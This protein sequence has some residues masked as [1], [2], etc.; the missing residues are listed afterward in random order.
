MCTVCDGVTFADPSPH[1][2]S[3]G[4]DDDTF[5]RFMLEMYEQ[6]TRQPELRQR[7]QV[8]P[9]ATVPDVCACT[10]YAVHVQ[11]LLTSRCHAVLCAAAGAGAATARGGAES[12]DPQGD[13]VVRAAAA[14]AAR[15]GQRRQAPAAAA[16]RA[17]RVH[18]HSHIWPLARVSFQSRFSWSCQVYYLAERCVIT[19][20]RIANIIHAHMYLMLPR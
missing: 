12:E 13:A 10:S 19:V 17:G 11:L 2:T 1:N 4:F 3:L 14:Q 16:P 7:H 6:Y 18:T 5:T 15:Q 20:L 9:R 8:S